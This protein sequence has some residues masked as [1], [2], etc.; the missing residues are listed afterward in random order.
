MEEVLKSASSRP[1]IDV[2]EMNIGRPQYC[3]MDSRTMYNFV[4]VL[5]GRY[6]VRCNLAEIVIRGSSYKDSEP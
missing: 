5:S 3:T 2:V 4:R 1:L 6:T